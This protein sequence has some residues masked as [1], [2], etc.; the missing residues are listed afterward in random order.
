V[1]TGSPVAARA[2]AR[3]SSAA[4]PSPW[5]VCG[6][7]RGLYAPPRSMAAPAARTARAASSSMPPL[8]RAR[9]GHHH[10]LGA[11]D[12]DG[13]GDAH[14]PGGRRGERE[15]GATGGRDGLLLDMAL[16]AE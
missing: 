2:A 11:A 1:T 5:K 3:C 15:G 12:G 14:R 6:E 4:S 8:D 9:A 13:V 16:P 10:E 7:V